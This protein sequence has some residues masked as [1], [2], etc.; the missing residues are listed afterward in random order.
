MA[1]RVGT[2]SQQKY[3]NVPDKDHHGSDFRLLLD[4]LRANMSFTEIDDRA[5]AHCI[6]VLQGLALARTGKL[7]GWDLETPFMSLDL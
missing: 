6:G 2:G 4:S 1:G 3:V 7:E 5:R